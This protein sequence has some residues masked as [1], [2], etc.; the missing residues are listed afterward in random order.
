MS[1]RVW[2]MPVA[3][4]E[5]VTPKKKLR[6]DKL[7][8]CGGRKMAFIPSAEVVIGRRST[9]V[10]IYFAFGF[11]KFVPGVVPQPLVRVLT[12]VNYDD[13][14]CFWRCLSYHQTKPEDPRNLN[15]IMKCIFNEYYNKEKDTKN[16]NGV[17]YVAYDK[18]YTDE[19]LDNEEYD[20]MNDEIDLIE[21][22]F[23]ISINVYTHD[24]PELL[25]IDRSS[26]I[27]IMI[28]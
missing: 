1:T 5:L 11:K 15:K 19:A 9:P 17:E 8:S 6:H 21:K 16:C 10:K 27:Y 28:L 4:T 13:Y 20:K 22:H 7:D 26:N 14:L 25:Q 24:E 12:M 3:L 18:E 23:N 2:N